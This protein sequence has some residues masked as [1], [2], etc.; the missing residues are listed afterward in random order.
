MHEYSINTA[1]ESRHFETEEFEGNYKGIYKYA[2]LSDVISTLQSLMA[3]YGDGYLTIDNEYT[4]EC[5][6]VDVRDT[7]FYNSN[8]EPKKTV[9]FFHIS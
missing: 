1:L 4:D 2:K 7:T 9:R 3:E 6:G 8:G 5:G